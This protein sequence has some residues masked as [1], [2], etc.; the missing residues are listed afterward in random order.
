GSNPQR[1]LTVFIK[2]IDDVAGQTVGGREIGE[3]ASAVLGQP[4]TFCA[5]PEIALPVFEQRLNIV[6]L[7]LFGVAFVEHRE[8]DSVK[9]GE[10]FLR[11]EPDVSVASL[12]DSDDVVLW[13]SG[14]GLPDI[15]NVLPNRSAGLQS[16]SSTG[17]HKD[18]ERENP[19][20]P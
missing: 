16:E 3:H 10:A 11:C 17:D 12:N 19:F 7:Y 8:L 6:V 18:E 20:E 9:A 14:V 1:A 5:E 4:P 13:E 2:R 15:L